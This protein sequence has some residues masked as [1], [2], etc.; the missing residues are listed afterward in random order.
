MKHKVTGIA[1]EVQLIQS[2]NTCS[3]TLCTDMASLSF[4]SFAVNHYSYTMYIGPSSYGNRQRLPLVW[5]CVYFVAFGLFSLDY[6]YS[7]T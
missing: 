2:V 5:I 3:Y 6:K 4:L 1:L 7:H